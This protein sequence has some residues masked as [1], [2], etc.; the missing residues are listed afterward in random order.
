MTNEPSFSHRLAVFNEGV[1]RDT[2]TSRKRRRRIVDLLVATCLGLI[3]WI[4]ILGLTLPRRYVRFCASD[5]DGTG[6]GE[7]SIGGVHA[8][9][10]VMSRLLGT[11]PT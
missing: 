11:S 2:D 7:G 3:P 5:R 6:G 4:V 9:A 10:E 8:Y 1:F